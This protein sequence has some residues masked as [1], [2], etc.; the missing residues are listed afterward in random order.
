MPNLRWFFV[1]TIMN[2]VPVERVP[3]NRQLWDRFVR[4]VK[5]F[6]ADP[7]VGRTALLRFG[8]LILF[9]FGINGLNVV[10]SYVGRDFMTAIADRDKAGF[11]TQAL[12][13]LGVFAALT[14]VAVISRYTE[15]SLGLLWREWLTRLSLTRYLEHKNYYRLALAG[16]L[17]NPDQRIADDVRAFTATT[18][19]FTLML[20][21]SSFTVV[22]FSGVLWTISPVLF[23][24]AVLYAGAGS[25]LAIRLGRPLIRLNYDQLDKEADFRSSLI[26]IRENADAIALLGREGRLHARLLRRLG[27][28]AANF[29]KIIRINRNLGFF[30]TGYNWLIQIIPALLVAPLYFDGKVEFGVVTQAAMAFSVLL[31]AFSLIVTQFQSISSFAAV[32]ARV[33]ALA[34]A[35]DA[36]DP[37]PR[38][39]APAI[40]IAEDE[41][42]IAYE[43]LTLRSPRSDRTLIGG[44]SVVIPHGRRV[45]AAGSDET[46]RAGLLR[47][48]A[49]LWDTGEGR[50]ARPGQEHVMFLPERPYLHSGTLRELLLRTKSESEVPDERIREVL[51]AL[52]IESILARFG[53]L[54]T[55]HRW[56][57]ILPLGEQQ[58]LAAARLVLAAPR[59]AFLDRP[60]S[61]LDSVTV[62]RLLGLFAR[63]SISYVIFDETVGSLGRYDAVLELLADGRWRWS[64]V[65]NGR[66]AEQKQGGG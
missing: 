17:G 3:L 21:N 43:R 38:T 27:D 15:E 56:G 59:F 26:Q 52:N 32:I 60:E 57:G 46:A 11:V 54:D 35:I 6:T 5:R 62:E 16:E 23:V 13:Y 9:L 14:A 29:R 40:E 39:E 10:N 36:V 63:H 49:G 58:L 61:A 47:A 42:Q 28:L 12:N 1:A 34:E 22:A 48:T 44:L 2:V 31:G 24:V 18:L 51:S 66:M 55:E 30:T 25:Y 64:S 45:L 20:L 53:G 50:I 33:G 8:L 19:S 65:V 7:E 37:E 4:M 41:G